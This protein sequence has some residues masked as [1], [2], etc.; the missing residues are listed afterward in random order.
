MKRQVNSRICFVC[1]L[2]NPIG[3]RLVFGDHE[4][5]TEDLCLTCHERQ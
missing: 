5:R 2:E 1:G 4:G 3:L